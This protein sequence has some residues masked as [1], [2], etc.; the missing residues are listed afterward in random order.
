MF[1][2]IYFY[3]V[4]TA[5]GWQGKGNLNTRGRRLLKQTNFLGV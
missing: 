3:S 5:L 2:A 1:Y 4:V